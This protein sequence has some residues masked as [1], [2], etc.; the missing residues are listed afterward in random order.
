V[1]YE[2]KGEVKVFMRKRRPPLVLLL[3]NL[4]NQF[5]QEENRQENIASLY[6]IANVLDLF[7][8]QPSLDRKFSKIVVGDFVQNF[9]ALHQQARYAS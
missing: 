5:P 6:I 2:W 9:Q 4:L 8:S 7:A 1:D 3:S